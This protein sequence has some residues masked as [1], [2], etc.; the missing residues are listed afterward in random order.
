VP[1]RVIHLDGQTWDLDALKLTVSDNSLPAMLERSRLGERFGPSALLGLA[2]SSTTSSASDARALLRSGFGFDTPR[3]ADAANS[4]SNDPL[5]FIADVKLSPTQRARVCRRLGGSPTTVAAGDRLSVTAAKRTWDARHFRRFVLDSARSGDPAVMGA[6]AA[7]AASLR[8]HDP[9]TFA[10]RLTG[11]QTYPLA[12]GRNT[13]LA[14]RA[15]D[16]LTASYTLAAFDPSGLAL[17]PL[18]WNAAPPTWRESAAPWVYAILDGVNGPAA[19][20]VSMG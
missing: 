2:A 7:V 13:K 11:S 14:Q 19:L 4:V 17:G 15:N 18:A 12:S 5:G 20:S 16:V 1:R 6:A 3:A 8:R 9:S 10:A